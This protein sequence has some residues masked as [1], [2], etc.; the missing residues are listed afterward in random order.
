[1]SAFCRLH[2]LFGLLLASFSCLAQ[3]TA[4]T[5]ADSYVPG[6]TPLV[7]P[8]PDTVVSTLATSTTEPQPTPDTLHQYSPEERYRLGRQEARLTYAP[9]KKVFWGCF[10]AGIAPLGPVSGVGTA[11]AVGL[12]PAKATTLTPRVPTQL[13][14]PDFRRGYQRQAQQ[15]KRTRAFLGAGAGSAVLAG[16]LTLTAALMLGGVADNVFTGLY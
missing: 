14:D 12:S 5:Q 1:M 16:V 9:P 7:Q 11:L 15:R 8:A 4:L 6:P 2:L 10:A 3:T 13:Q